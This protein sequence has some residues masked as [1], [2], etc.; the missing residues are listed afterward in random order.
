MNALHDAASLTVKK[1][2]LAKELLF[3]VEQGFFEADSELE[4]G[5]PVVF[6]DRQEMENFSGNECDHQCSPAQPL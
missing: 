5:F 6:V 3:N 1:F 4:L 2:Y